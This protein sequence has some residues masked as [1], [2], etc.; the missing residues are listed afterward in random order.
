RAKIWGA[1]LDLSS[2]FLN[3]VTS[4][5]S[6]TFKHGENSERKTRLPYSP[7]H[8]FFGYIQFENEYLKK[9]IGIKLRIE[10]SVISERFMDE[11]E[12]DKEPGVAIMNGKVTIRFLDFHFY[13]IVRNVTNQNYRL[14]TDYHM[15]KR[16]FWW[17]FYWEF[18]D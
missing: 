8:N 11:Y 13:Y 16:T 7:D 12:K 18:F 15:P 10:T 1:N 4:Y 6:Y 17:G 9:E 5:I 14:S 2:K 3:Y